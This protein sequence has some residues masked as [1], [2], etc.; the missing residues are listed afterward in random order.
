ML[1]NIAVHDNV[2]LSVQCRQWLIQIGYN[3]LVA[4]AL[5]Q[6]CQFRATFDARHLKPMLRKLLRQNSLGRAYI[7]QFPCFSIAHMRKN[8]RVTR[9]RIAYFRLVG[10]PSAWI[11]H[12]CINLSLTRVYCS[13]VRHRQIRRPQGESK[14]KHD[15]PL[16]LR[17]R[18]T[19]AE[20]FASLASHGTE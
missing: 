1:Q 3:H 2:E 16:R 15:N 8:H 12:I 4:M 13:T 9:M 18:L 5:T 11:V 17:E 20:R 10:K 14:V 19:C 7:Q 6:G